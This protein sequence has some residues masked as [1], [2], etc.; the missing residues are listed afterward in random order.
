MST[1]I[2]SILNDVRNANGPKAKIV[3]LNEYSAND[4]LKTFLS[5]IHD[6][7][8]NLHIRTIPHPSVLD[9]EVVERITNT[10]PFDEIGDASDAIAGTIISLGM[11]KAD[12][13]MVKSSIAALGLAVKTHATSEEYAFLER[14]IARDLL[15]GATASTINKVWK[16]LIPT[17]KVMKAYDATNIDSIKYPARVEMKMDG[18]RGVIECTRD[19]GVKVR[20]SSGAEL[21]QTGNLIP[22]L[23]EFRS[24]YASELYD[25]F[26]L[27]GEIIFLDEHGKRLPRETTNGLASK[28]LKGN[29][30]EEEESRMRFYVFD[31]L[32]SANQLRIGVDSTPLKKR[33]VYAGFFEKCAIIPVDGIIAES[34]E[35]VDEYFS[36]MRQEGEEGVVI[37]N[38][39]SLYVTKKSK[40]WIKVK[41]QTDC[42]LVITDARLMKG[43]DKDIGSLTI[44]TSDGKYSGSIGSGLNEEQRA[45]MFELHSQGALVGTIVAVR[46]HRLT[47]A[48]KFYLP[49]IIEVRTDKFE[50]DSSEKVDELILLG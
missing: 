14:A 40:D 23:E 45:K 27:D 8:V 26:T 3:V 4:Q 49:R 2:L 33:L 46:F 6:P 10:N 38:L 34:K 15:I 16:D 25:G 37:K 39:D 28:A 32:S 22:S 24:Y 29:L 20:S 19:G 43:S 31:C 21:K 44:E 36:I 12:Y 35:E 42:D 18:Y 30:T 17:F 1:T 11:Q 9:D 41:I 47:A 7:F 5:V 48:G 50:A 13:G